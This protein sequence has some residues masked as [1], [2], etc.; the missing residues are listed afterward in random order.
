MIFNSNKSIILL[1][2][3]VIKL[4]K[5]LAKI[6]I[7]QWADTKRAVNKKTNIS[8]CEADISMQI[9]L[10][11]HYNSNKITHYLIGTQEDLL[12]IYMK[13]KLPEMVKLMRRKNKLKYGACISSYEVLN[14]NQ[15]V[16]KAV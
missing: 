2:V 7:E 14:C 12:Q 10:C 13:S 3:P 4:C 11:I 8:C 6:F 5:L 16:I 1:E 9:N 15:V